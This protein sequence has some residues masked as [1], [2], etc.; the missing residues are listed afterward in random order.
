MSIILRKM[1]QFIWGVPTLILILS[2]GIYLTIRTKFVQFRM[3]PKAVRSFLASF[4]K[5]NDI[6]GVSPFRA[7]CTALAATVGTGNLAGVAGAIAIGGPGSIFWMWICAVLGMVIKLAEAVLSVRY[8]RQGNNGEY[9]GGPMYMIRFGMGRQWSWLAGTYAFLG[10]VA[11]LGVGNGTQINTAV[12][13]INSAITAYGGT[14][15]QWGNALIGISFAVIIGCVL[16]GGT[17]R[18]G[19]IAEMLVPFAAGMYIL[20]GIG[21]LLVR[22]EVIPGAITAIIQ[23]A[24]QPKAVTGGVVGSVMKTLHVGISRGV[25]TN[26]A[27]M[28]TAGIAHGCA[29]VK[30]P[31]EQGLMGIMEVFIDTI[32]ICTITALVILCSGVTIAYGSNTG[33]ELTVHAFSSVYGQ[34][35]NIFLA[36]A[37]TCFAL[38]T[39]L[40]WGLY[41]IRCAEYLFG[42]D[43]RRLFAWLQVLTTVISAI[44]NAETVWLFA[45]I[46][47]GLMA[48]PNLIAVGYL[49]TDLVNLVNQYQTERKA[50]RKLKRYTNQI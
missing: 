26:E 30:H 14:E 12:V 6:D 40:G 10:I 42:K 4:C 17:R 15:T 13:G 21:I 46:I 45:E 47:N 35:S 29:N 50:K 41:G 36:A 49:S 37:T 2:V 22:F 20:L 1:N 18:I 44:L 38:A 23:G 19:L 5:R 39:V 24:F 25:F 7:L 8:R 11:A 32:V 28:G 27:G 33:A 43:I 16:L 48:I 9:L 3:F 31:V 34:W